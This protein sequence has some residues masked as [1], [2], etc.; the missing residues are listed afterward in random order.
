MALALAG[1]AGASETCATETPQPNVRRTLEKQAGKLFA[2]GAVDRKSLWFCA[3]HGLDAEAVV[4]S[5]PR[6]LPDGSDLVRQAWC[7]RHDE[8]NRTRWTCRPH[9]YRQTEMIVKIDGAPWRFKVVLAPESDPVFAR[10]LVEQA[11]VLSSQ[12]TAQNRCGSILYKYD[13]ETFNAEFATRPSATE[14]PTFTLYH[15]PGAWQVSRRLSSLTLE[16]AEGHEPRFK[17]WAAAQEA[18]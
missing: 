13:L 8:G 11:I 1:Q 2:P 9:E 18:L 16:I 7:D 12:A 3:H 6:R 4:E 14:N 17:C 15:A 5:M 10:R